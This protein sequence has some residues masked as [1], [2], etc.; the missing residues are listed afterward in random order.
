MLALWP[1]TILSQ[2]CSQELH[3]MKKAVKVKEDQCKDE[4]KALQNMARYRQEILK[5]KK[6]FKINEEVCL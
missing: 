6:K 3:D 5:L 1:G 2:S 4:A